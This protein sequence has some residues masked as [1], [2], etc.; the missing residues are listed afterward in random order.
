MAE[1]YTIDFP[2]HKVSG[3]RKRVGHAAFHRLEPEINKQREKARWYFDALKEIKGI[4]LI[5]EAEQ[6][7]AVYPYITLLFDE[8]AKRD[9]ALELFHNK[10]L[11][12]STAY[13]YAITDY[14]YLKPIIPPKPCPNAQNISSRHITLSTNTFLEKKMLRSF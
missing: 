2:I 11:G 9:R 14:D 5:K 6:T 3:F 10:G 8:P 12:I 13:L 7:K 4:K 1:Y